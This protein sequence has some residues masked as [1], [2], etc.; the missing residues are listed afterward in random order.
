LTT[1][2]RAF[3]SERIDGDLFAQAVRQ[4]MRVAWRESFLAGVR[5][6]GHPAVGVSRPGL[7][8]LDPADE[9]WLEGAMRHEM[10]FLNRFIRDVRTGEGR[11]PYP[12]RARMYVDALQSFF[13]SGRVIGLPANVLIYWSGPNDKRTCASCAYL[14]AYHRFTKATLP[15][16]PRSGLTLCLSNCRDKLLVRQEDPAK[17]VDVTHEG[18]TRETHIRNLRTI[19]RQGHL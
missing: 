6:A 15:T 12:R 11:M 2:I 3:E 17:V 5:A 13:D 18:P 14:F 9:K 4:A 1:A 10:T 16:A 7:A 8:K 19:K